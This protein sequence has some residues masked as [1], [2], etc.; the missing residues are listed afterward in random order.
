MT[1]H[2]WR[3]TFL[4]LKLNKRVLN[5]FGFRMI[6]KAKDGYDNYHPLF[7]HHSLP[8][9]HHL[10]WQQ[11]NAVRKKSHITLL[12]ASTHKKS[13]IFLILDAIKLRVRL[14][15]NLENSLFK[16]NPK[17]KLTTGDIKIL[18]FATDYYW[19]FGINIKNTSLNSYI[20]LFTIL[21][22]FFL[23]RCGCF[24]HIFRLARFLSHGQVRTV[25]LV[26]AAYKNVCG[27]IFT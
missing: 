21:L 18:C 19:D 16:D 13:K 2:S 8:W 1:P 14:R 24:G 20:K 10:K 15:R 3:S 7:I 11:R 17:A 25:L 9:K 5:Y 23:I 22:I 4:N 26:S 6:L 27:L 12:K